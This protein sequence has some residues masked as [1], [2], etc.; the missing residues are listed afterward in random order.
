MERRGKDS[1]ERRG[2]DPKMERRGEDP[3]ERR[4]DSRKNSVQTVIYQKNSILIIS[5]LCK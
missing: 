2:E 4:K 1:R 3:K 5:A